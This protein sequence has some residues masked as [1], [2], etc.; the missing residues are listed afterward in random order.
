MTKKAYF[1]V[2][3]RFNGR[4]GAA[5]VIVERGVGLFGVREFRRRRVYT[6]PLATVAEMV[7]YAIVKREAVERA[8]ARRAKRQARRK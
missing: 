7:V 5:R 2:V 4:P 8:Q 3:G 6:L 1:P